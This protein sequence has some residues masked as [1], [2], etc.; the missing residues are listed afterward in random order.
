MEQVSFFCER[1]SVD[2]VQS[3]QGW[4]WSEAQVLLKKVLFFGEVQ[5]RWAF[6]R[7]EEPPSPVA[8]HEGM[9]ENASAPL[10]NELMP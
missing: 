1:F 7:H 8:Q 2:S 5:L 3:G 6:C 9:P 10:L 4:I